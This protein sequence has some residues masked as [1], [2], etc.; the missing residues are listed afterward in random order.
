MKIKKILILMLNPNVDEVVRIYIKIMCILKKNKYLKLCEW[1]SNRMQ[2]KY[3]VYIS[4]KANFD[5]SLSLKHPIGIVIGQGV[6]LGRNVVIFQ[7][8]TIGRSSNNVAQ[9]PSVGDNTTIYAGAVV[10]GGIHVG[11]NCIVGANSVVTSNIPDNSVVVGCP[12]RV[13]GINK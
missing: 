12:A 5:E 6:N 9:Y 3:G 4:S 8:V 1:F 11:H 10:I 2:R 13:V 7:N